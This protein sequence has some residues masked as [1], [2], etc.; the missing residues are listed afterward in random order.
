MAQFSCHCRLPS[1]NHCFLRASDPRTIA[2]ARICFLLSQS[3]FH[4]GEPVE[5]LPGLHV[6]RDGAKF[7]RHFGGLL[8]RRS[9]TLKLPR[10]KICDEF[11]SLSTW[12]M[13]AELLY[14]W[15][16]QL[17]RNFHDERIRYTLLKPQPACNRLRSEN[18][19]DYFRFAAWNSFQSSRLFK[20]TASR[21]LQF[22]SFKPLAEKMPLRVLSSWI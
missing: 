12:N 19:S 21:N 10:Y 17:K 16:G 1:G 14:Q 20:F 15:R 13:R 4:D 8:K 2:K 7:V 22:S 5:R 6:L 11:R 9:L 18:Q 3:N